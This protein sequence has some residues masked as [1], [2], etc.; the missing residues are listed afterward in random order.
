MN[1]KALTSAEAFEINYNA[2]YTADPI[3]P[4]GEKCG[5]ERDLICFKF[6]VCFKYTAKPKSFNATPKLKYK[7]TAEKD[8]SGPPRVEFKKKSGK[9]KSSFLNLSKLLISC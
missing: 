7:L 8:E 5:D 2:F 1:L 3:D 9:G 4:N 6:K